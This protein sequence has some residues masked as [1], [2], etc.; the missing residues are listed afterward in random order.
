[1]PRRQ[2]PEPSDSALRRVALYARVSTEDQA[3]ADTISTQVDFLRRYADLHGLHVAAEFLDDGVSGTIPLAE[4]PHG[5]RLLAAARAGEISAVVFYRVSRLGRRLA[6]VLDAYEQFDRANVVIRSATEPIDTAQPIGRFIFQMLAAFAELDRETIIDNTSRGRARGARD[7]R[8][9]G[10]VP[11]G[12]TVRDG[13]LAPSTHEILPGMTE[14][15][16]VR[17]I[18]RRIAD[19][20]SSVAVAAYLTARGLHRFKRYARHDGRESVIDGAPGWP[21]KRISEMVHNTT[22]KGIHVYEGRNGHI[23]RAVPAL[24]DA[25]LWDRAQQ[26]LRANRS[27]TSPSRNVYLLR[28]LLRCG[29]CGAGYVGSTRGQNT[30]VYRCAH[31]HPRSVGLEGEPCRSRQLQADAIERDVWADCERFIRDPGSTVDA[32]M[33]EE[34]ARR[35]AEPDDAPVLLE[36]RAALAGKDRERSDILTLMRRRI[37]SIDEAEAQLQAIADEQQALRRELDQVEARASLRENGRQQAV[38]ARALLEDLRARLDDGLDDAARRIVVQALVRRLDVFTEPG[39]TKRGGRRARI[40]AHYAFAPKKALVTG[41]C[42]STA[43]ECLFLRR[44]WT[45]GSDGAPQP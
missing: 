21:A 36:L 1:M 8:W 25:D 13:Q 3:E 29:A 28:S 37:V 11:T 16:L 39:A 38:A 9:Y 17:D 32:A 30:R 34:E 7:G 31:S 10:V 20:A 6:V 35:M 23:E 44:Q 5:A 4:R 22:Y 24:V 33:A 43:N 26:R 42:C 40:V 18:Y 2:E 14:A 19:G 27:T 15:D 12:Y 45:L 41:S